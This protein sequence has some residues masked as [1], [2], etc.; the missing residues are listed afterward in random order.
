MTKD[1]AGVVQEEL[2]SIAVI[3]LIPA[4]ADMMSM[5]TENAG[6]MMFIGMTPITADR[7]NTR[8]AVLTTAAPGVLT[9]VQEAMFTKGEPVMTRVVQV[10]LVIVTK[11]QK[12]S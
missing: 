10:V 4:M 12:R 9:I 11:I 5:I 3:I 7:T 2:A 8:N 6:I 1:Q